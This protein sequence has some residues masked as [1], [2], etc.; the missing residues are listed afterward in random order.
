MRV[1][2]LTIYIQALK[3]VIRCKLK[4]L[5]WKGRGSHALYHIVQPVYFNQFYMKMKQNHKIAQKWLV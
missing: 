3:M 4:C 2:C 1:T 5:Y